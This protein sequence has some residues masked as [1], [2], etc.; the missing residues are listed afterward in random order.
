MFSLYFL[1]VLLAFHVAIPAYVNSSFLETFVSSEY[2]GPVYALGSI[3]TILGL[4]TLPFILRRF[5][6]YHTTNVL[7]LLEIIAFAGLTLASRDY[8]L[9]AFFLL[10]IMIGSFIYFSFD[11]F[12]EGYS[13]DSQTGKIRGTFLTLTNLAWVFAP[14]TAAFLLQTENYRL[15]YLCPLILLFPILFITQRLRRFH[16]S[17]YVA[18]PFLVT[19]KEILHNRNIRNIFWV[20]LL[21]RFFYSWMVIYTPIYLHKYLGI[22]WSEIGVIFGIMLIPF[23][24]TPYPLGK[25][26]DKKYGEKEM[27][28]IGFIVMAISTAL[29][30]FIDSTNMIVWAG[31]LFVTRIGA[32]VIEIMSETYFFKKVGNV[33]ANMIGFFRTAGPMAYILG[34]LSATVVL[35]YTNLD[36]KYLFLILGIIMLF[37][38]IFSL[39]IKDTK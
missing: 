3:L 31:I 9:T 32:S 17:Q 5:G 10:A 8:A 21:L 25:L 18:V 27:L 15:I 16:D 35:V 33:N 28:I 2:V 4:W 19:A 13:K 34:P 20:G 26:A 36:M 39:R 7:I 29:V 37:G 6:N 14:M 23:I 12:M 1:A 38:I 22:A 24:L 30:S 11:I